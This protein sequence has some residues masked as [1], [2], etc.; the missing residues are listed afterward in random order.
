MATGEKKLLY[1]TG[2]NSEYG[3]DKWGL[4]AKTQGGQSVDGKLL[5]GNVRGQ[6]G[7]WLQLLDRTLAEGWPGSSDITWGLVREEEF[8]Q[9]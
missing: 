8:D 3:T 6:G 9:I 1:R 7:F 2:F 4:R 5:R